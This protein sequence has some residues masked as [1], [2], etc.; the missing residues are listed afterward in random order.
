MFT[1]HLQNKEFY[2]H[3]SCIST[4]NDATPAPRVFKKT[5]LNLLKKTNPKKSKLE[6]SVVA[7]RDAFFSIKSVPGDGRCI[8]NCFS[9]HC[10][11]KLHEKF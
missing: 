7:N 8:V 5:Q 9:R 1:C 6:G 2:L 11:R 3:S 10:W 4:F